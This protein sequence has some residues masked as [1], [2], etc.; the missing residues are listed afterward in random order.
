[1]P[2]RDATPGVPGGRAEGLP[3]QR[4]GCVSAHCYLWLD[5]ARL[6]AQPWDESAFERE[7]LAG[8]AERHGAADAGRVGPAR[9]TP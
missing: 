8:F 5:P 2:A 7:H 6:L 3:V 9:G 1:L 4:P